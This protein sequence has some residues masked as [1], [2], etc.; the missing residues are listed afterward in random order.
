MTSVTAVVADDEP[1]V[2][3]GLRRSLA[4]AD[5]DVVGEARNG[6]EAVEKVLI[7][8]PDLLFLDVQMPEMDGVTALR[9]IP[10]T[11]RPVTIFVTAYDQYAVQAFE[12]HAADYLLKPFDEARLREALDRARGRRR[13]GRDE[14]EAMLDALKPPPRYL[15][16]FVVRTGGKIVLV[17]V[18]DV[19]WVEA[20]DNYVRLHAGR[21]RHVFRETLKRLE[22][23]LDPA[24]FIRIHRS[25]LVRIGA[26]AEL[27]PLPSGD[28]EVLLRSGA[29]L[30]L[31]RG[32]RETFDRRIGHW[33]G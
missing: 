4:L 2:R 21:H 18:A 13:R 27:K 12:L 26:I 20:A 9:T 22:A 6:R 31:S 1:L 17:S 23:L 33:S 29:K 15:E 8:K 25:A 19:E 3:R 24:L 28:C 14:I 32:Y 5:V 30:S 11:E 7:L 16:R 10:A